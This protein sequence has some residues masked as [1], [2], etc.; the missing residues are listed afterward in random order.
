[1]P[2]KQAVILCFS[3]PTYT[4]VGKRTKLALIWPPGES[5][6]NIYC[7]VRSFFILFCSEGVYMKFSTLFKLMISYSLRAIYSGLSF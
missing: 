5:K 3:L 4:S 7:A 6:S 2:Q 1:M